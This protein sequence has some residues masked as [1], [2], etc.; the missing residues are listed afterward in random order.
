MFFYPLFK[1]LIRLFKGLDPK[2]VRMYQGF[3]NL[4]SGM[5]TQQRRLNVVS[6]NMANI[7]TAGYK[8]GIISQ[9]ILKWF[10]IT[11]PISIP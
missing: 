9:K 4:T 8:K 1:K 3:Y 7:E 5:L 11:S 2:G 10:P 6:N